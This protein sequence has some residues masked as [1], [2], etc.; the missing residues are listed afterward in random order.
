[1]AITE[2]TLEGG[3]RAVS[4][5]TEEKFARALDRGLP[6]VAP[7]EIAAAFGFPIHQDGQ[8]TDDAFGAEVDDRSAYAA[9]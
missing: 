8:E 7:E 2:I 9:A 6:I 5:D 1:M 3:E 4:V